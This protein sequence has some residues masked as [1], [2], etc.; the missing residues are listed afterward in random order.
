MS[1]DQHGTSAPTG[2][3]PDDTPTGSLMISS[4]DI[5]STG[6]TGTGNTPHGGV[7]RHAA[8][9][10]SGERGR[11]EIAD[12]VIER[13]ARAATGE[14]AHVGGAARRVLGL[15]TGREDGEGAPQVSA[16]VT[17]D[18]ATVAVRLSVTYPASVRDTTEAVRAHVRERVAALTELTVSRVDISVTALN[19]T[20]APTGRV[21]A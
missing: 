14:V 21:I 18:L 5:T 2:P 3:A 1:S 13:V 11:L 12:V 4:S 8:A 15:P 16:T 19:R 20:S 10:D 9:P 17:G 6:V 7:G